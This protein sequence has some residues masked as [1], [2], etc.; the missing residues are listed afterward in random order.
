[1]KDDKWVD[2]WVVSS[3]SGDGDYIVARDKD[4]NWACSCIGW[5]RHVPRRDCR[6]ITE[7]KEGGGKTVS[8]AVLDRLAG[9]R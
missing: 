6:H 8:E 5:T 7:V 3:S 1:M 4:G 9:R 2:R